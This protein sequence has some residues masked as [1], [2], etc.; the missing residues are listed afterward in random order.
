MSYFKVTV[1][2]YRCFGY[3]PQEIEISDGFT[4]LIGLN[5]SGK[6]A[7]LRM[8]YELRPIWSHLSQSN[9]LHILDRSNNF[10]LNIL[11]VED[12]DEIFN[13][14]NN[15]AIEIGFTIR[16]ADGHKLNPVFRLNHKNSS[17]VTLSGL[18]FTYDDREG[19]LNGYTVV[20]GQH[21]AGFTH[22][23]GTGSVNVQLNELYDL[24]KTLHSI[25][26]I[27]AFRNVVNTGEKT[28]LYDISTGTAFISK[29]DEWKAGTIKAN[30]DQINRITDDIKQLFGYS[31][32]EITASTDK[33]T[34]RLS[35]NGKSYSLAD[36]GSGLSQFILSY[37]TAAISKPSFIFI[38]EPELNLHPALQLKFLASLGVY[39]KNGVVFSTHSIGLA[40]SSAEAIYS[41]LNDGT[42]AKIVPFSGTPDYLSLLG[43]LSFSAYRELGAECLFFVEGPTEVKVMQELLRKYGKDA[44]TLI[45]S[46]GGDSMINGNREQELSEIVTRVKVNKLFAWIDSEKTSDTDVL[47]KNRQDFLTMCARLNITAKASDKRAIENYFT[48]NAIRRALEDDSKTNLSEYEKLDQGSH[49]SKNLNW[50]IAKSSTKEEIDATDLGVFLSSII[51]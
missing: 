51:V 19:V 26:Y 6:S 42:E 32:L 11:G 17:T 7:L 22:A 8:F 31:S 40:R 14:F 15:S 41:I 36:V 45:M 27:P 33:T 13:H 37:A 29:W 23:D 35:I 10:D 50:K 38:D 18:S 2:N 43:E 34:L 1:R 16:T 21:Q 3:E 5:N 12:T 39:A 4:A 49:W 47:A 24:F 44:Q 25:I 46:L 9:N 30:R 28:S 48:E 20:N